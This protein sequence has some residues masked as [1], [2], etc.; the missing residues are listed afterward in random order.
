MLV[1]FLQDEAGR[2]CKLS[3]PW[4]GAY[5][6]VDRRDPDVMVV[7]V[8]APQEGQIQVHQSRVSPCPPG[9][10]AEYFWYGVRR[11]SPGRP[12]RWVDKLLQDATQDPPSSVDA[13]HRQDPPP[14]CQLEMD[15]KE[16][17]IPS[18]PTNPVE[19]YTPTPEKKWTKCGLRD[20]SIS[21]PPDVFELGSSSPGEESDVTD[22]N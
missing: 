14:S 1:K 20:R 22:T 19:E 12:P 8:Y 9:S 11:S 21:F 17:D 6:I 3:R 13:D 5:R 2:N 15:S 18:T 16:G 7:K 10:P 4:H